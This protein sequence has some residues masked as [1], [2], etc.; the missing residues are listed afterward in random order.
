MTLHEM[1]KDV[2]RQI[3]LLGDNDASAIQSIWLYVSALPAVHN[4][5]HDAEKRAKAKEL[6]HS[7]LGVF[8][9]SRTDKDWKEVK[10]TYLVEKYGDER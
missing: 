4:K 9:P 3:S 8:S 6:A 1:K 10:E 7:F 2:V 5:K